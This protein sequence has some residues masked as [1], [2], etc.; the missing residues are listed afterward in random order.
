MDLKF[1]PPLS[2]QT[3]LQQYW[4][5]RPLL[6][7]NALT[8][9]DFPLS[10]DELAGLACEDEVESRI[11][12]EHSR[13]QW[14]LQHG[15]FSEADFAA[16]GDSHW[17]LLVQ[18]TDKYVPQIAELLRR[19]HFIPSWR[20]DDIMISYATPQGSVGPHTDTYDVFLIQAQG[21]REWRIDTRVANPALLPDLPV[22]I[23]AEF[24]AENSWLLE[25]GDVLYLPPGVAH[26]GIAQDE[27]MTW[28][29]GLR[30]PSASEMIDSFAQ[31]LL[32]QA[33]ESGHYQDPP[34]NPPSSPAYIDSAVIRQNGRLLDEPWLDPALRR[35]WFGGFVTEIK[36]HLVIEPAAE[37]VSSELVQKRLATGRRLQRHPYARFAWTELDDSRLALFVCGQHYPVASSLEPEIIRLCDALHIDI[38]RNAAL[39]DNRFM[40]ILSE[41][42]N[43]GFLEWLDD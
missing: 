1:P 16:L 3:F 11:V 36:P 18:D 39:Q 2:Q 12:R 24:E 30:A 5:K 42:I 40:D 20:F 14:S 27:C 22:R 21:R 15:P 32:E 43:Q 31:Y 23:L 33:S 9:Y 41:L 6:M 28:S 7:R 10:A 19:F 35:Q 37:A 17:T 34:F 4:Q 29:V 26:W 38:H 8:D 13:H 25:P